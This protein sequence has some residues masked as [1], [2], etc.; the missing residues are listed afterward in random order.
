MSDWLLYLAAA[1]LVIT[2]AVHSVLGERR[3]IAPL[4]SMREGVL[5]SKLVR[6]LLRFVWHLISVCW[7]VL[8]L[9]LTQLV[10]DTAA[11][12]WWAAASTGTA[13]TGAGLVDLIY[14]R[15]RHIGWPMLMGI[16]IAA[17]L[18]LAL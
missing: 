2:S 9:I 11:I 8:A 5:A 18:S 13:F 3:L 17:L 7:V 14:S 15:G 10:R 4:L 16:G 6:F 12:R 1:L